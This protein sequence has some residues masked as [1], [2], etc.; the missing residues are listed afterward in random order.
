MKKL[1]PL[2]A[3]V[4]R[5]P[6]A[7]VHLEDVLQD[8]AE[9]RTRPATT[10]HVAAQRF[11]RKHLRKNRRGPSLV[12]RAASLPSPFAIEAFLEE[13]KGMGLKRKVLEQLRATCRV[14]LAELR[15]EIP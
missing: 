8:V 12:E 14:R 15:G 13:I 9:G 5:N 7:L 3:I 10:A 4:R 2:P 6:S 1:T 11:Y